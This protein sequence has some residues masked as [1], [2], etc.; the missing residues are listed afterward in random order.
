MQNDLPPDVH[1]FVSEYVQSISQLELLLLLHRNAEKSWSVAEATKELYTS[2][3]MTEP[4][5]ENLRGIGLVSL[6]EGSERRYR[7]APKST[8]LDRLVG[9]LDQLYAERRVTIINSI[10]SGPWRKLQ[11]VADAFRFRNKENE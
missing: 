10:Y 4:L 6:L 3:S 7:Y 9:D 8:E 11:N 1:Q 2:V 5:L